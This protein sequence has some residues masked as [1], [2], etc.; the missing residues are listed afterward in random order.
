MKFQRTPYALL[1]ILSFGIS[2]ASLQ[3]ATAFPFFDSTGIEIEGNRIILTVERADEH[4]DPLNQISRWLNIP[5]I[6][7]GKFNITQLVS[8]RLNRIPFFRHFRFNGV[9]CHNTVLMAVGI[10]N[11]PSYVGREEIEYHLDEYCHE[12]PRPV[13]HSI[14][15]KHGNSITNHSFYVIG[16]HVRFEKPD[17]LAKNSYRFII[18]EVPS[19]GFKYY[20]CRRRSNAAESSCRPEIESILRRVDEIDSYYSDLILGDASHEHRERF[21]K[22]IAPNQ[23]EIAKWIRRTSPNSSCMRLLRDMSHRLISLDV[24]AYELS[25]LGI[26]WQQRISPYSHRY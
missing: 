10:L 19:E 14:A 8:R 9:N 13:P 21:H 4:R 6:E 25:G 17:N 23:A 2:S 12:I 22:M 24:L 1:Y 16:S 3:W 11:R 18:G 20:S 7:S 5:S 15:Y 26:I